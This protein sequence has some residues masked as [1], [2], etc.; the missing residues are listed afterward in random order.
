MKD[1]GLTLAQFAVAGLWTGLETSI[2]ELMLAM[3]T[4][5][6]KLEGK[7]PVP[8]T[9]EA[10]MKGQMAS[11][12]KRTT[13]FMRL[14]RMMGAN[15]ISCPLSRQQ[16]FELERLNAIRNLVFHKSGIVDEKF[17]QTVRQPELPRGS[18]LV[19]TDVQYHHFFGVVGDFIT[20]AVT[21]VGN[22][23]VIK[24]AARE[25]YGAAPY[26]RLALEAY[27][28]KLAN[29]MKARNRPETP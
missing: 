11:A 20:A 6:E 21:S 9:V 28:R 10:K 2:F 12:P 3:L 22:H 8:R 16:Q 29:E 15:G 1:V 26:D 19:I 4:A 13:T 24:R 25:F 23:E 18:N 14:I 7:N 17:A 5:K 27:A